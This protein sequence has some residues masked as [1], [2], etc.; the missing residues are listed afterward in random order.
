[1]SNIIYIPKKGIVSPP[2]GFSDYGA[3]YNYDAVIDTRNITSAG[4]HIPDWNVDV[5]LLSS[6]LTPSL[7]G[8]KVMEIGTLHWIQNVNGTNESQFNGRGSG[9][10]E[11]DNG[12]FVVFGWMGCF[13]LRESWSVGYKALISYQDAS[14]YFG[15]TGTFGINTPGAPIRPIKDFTI[16][17]H[18]ETGIYTGN[19]GKIYSTICIGTQEWVSENL[20]ES[21]YRNGN[22]ISFAG[23]NGINYTDAEWA[24][25]T[26]EAMCFYPSI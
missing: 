22:L 3:L 9:Y 13:W 11:I 7:A 25:L 24:A 4:W 17:N 15:S 12:S 6:F 16:L 19:D 26:T 8:Y 10:R 23:V 1:M 5:S 14:G 18:G 21:E 2:I 20:A